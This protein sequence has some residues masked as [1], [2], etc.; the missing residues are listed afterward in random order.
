MEIP[1]TITNTEKGFMKV[2]KE[3]GTLKIQTNKKPDIFP[4]M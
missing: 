1:E 3:M 4:Y 2:A